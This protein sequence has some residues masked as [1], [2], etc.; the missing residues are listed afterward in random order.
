[1]SY[2][3]KAVGIHDL[4]VGKSYIPLNSRGNLDKAQAGTYGKKSA[5][6]DTATLRWLN[7]PFV[8]K[9]PTLFI[10]ARPDSQ[11]HLQPI[12]VGGRRSRKTLRKR[13]RSTTRR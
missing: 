1:M 4:E 9:V 5:N 10:K 3:D 11:G 7:E 12:T 13:R 8:F 2:L 6:P